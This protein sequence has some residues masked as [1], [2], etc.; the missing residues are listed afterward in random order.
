LKNYFFNK[1][2]T[3]CCSV[4]SGYLLSLVFLIAVAVQLLVE[5]LL[6]RCTMKG[7]RIIPNSIELIHSIH[8]IVEELGI[9]F[10]K[11]KRNRLNQKRIY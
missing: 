4:V 8:S 1:R 6:R 10:V 7:V 5:Y 11:K 3:C 2:K 9:S